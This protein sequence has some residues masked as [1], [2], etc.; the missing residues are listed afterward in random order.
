MHISERESPSELGAEETQ[1]Q[2]DQLPVD[3]TNLRKVTDLFRERNIRIGD[4]AENILS[5][6]ILTLE[7]LSAANEKANQ[8]DRP[9]VTQMRPALFR[10]GS[11]SV[12]I[13][14]EN[15]RR[16]PQPSQSLI[17][18]EFARLRNTAVR[19]SKVAEIVAN[20]VSP[21]VTDESRVAGL[22]SYVGQMLACMRFGQRF[23]SLSTR[24][25]RPA[26][27]YRL[28]QEL[29]FDVSRVQVDYLET[30]GVPNTLT[31]LFDR[32]VQCKTPLQATLRF[33]NEAAI[34]IVEMYDS[35]K[36]HR[37]APSQ[38]LP[39][40]SAL[41]LLRLGER[42][43]AAIY[44]LCLAYFKTEGG[45]RFESP[46]PAQKP[47]E[48]AAP[49][50]PAENLGHLAAPI[51]Y[52]EVGEATPREEPKPFSPQAQQLFEELKALFGVAKR[53]EEL[54]HRILELL[55]SRGPFH[56]AAL[57][58]VGPDRRTARVHIGL[59]SGFSQ[60]S[61]VAVQ[62]P[63]SPLATCGTSI[64]SFNAQD[65]VDLN[66]PFGIT[67]YAL[68]PIKVAYQDPVLLYADCGIEGALP[69]EARKVFR[70]VVGLLNSVLARLPGSLP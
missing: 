7:L 30:K 10:L 35:Q 65:T 23:T 15:L 8:I 43:H 33:L 37:Y 50:V 52:I 55:I 40:K 32:E 54:L 4:I 58:T 39:G 17:S 57:L 22:F 59:G 14:L 60:V 26:L 53:S 28:Q 36:F 27:V 41:R 64:R 70:L 51:E 6:P 24:L 25:S 12:L 47:E 13:L 38:E 62:D 61:L 56:R 44:E 66:A 45:K 69:F 16:R 31:F 2:V 48:P 29:R 11:E 20:I 63:F 9:A 21:D 1:A 46:E 49:E 3:L 5:D 18:S 68:S 19:V 34:E 67:A 42:Q